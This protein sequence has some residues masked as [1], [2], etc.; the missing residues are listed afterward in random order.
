M[1]DRDLPPERLIPVS[2]E[3][4]RLGLDDV[5][6]VEDL[7]WASGVASAA[8]VLAS[9]DRVRVGIG[10]MP[11][12]LRNAALLA[13][14]V[15]TLGRLHPGRFVAG[16]GH[17]VQDWMRQVGAAAPSPLTLLDETF[18]AVREL[19]SGRRLHLAGKAVSIDGVQLVHPP[20]APVPL[21]AGVTGPKS[22]ELAGRVADGVILVEGS[23]AEQIRD[24]LARAGHP[25]RDYEVVVFCHLFIADDPALV[26]RE[27]GTVA[28]E[29]FR[30]EERDFAIAAGTAAAAAD[31]V[32]S[33]W[34]SGASTVVLRPIGDPEPQ[35]AALVAAM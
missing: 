9:T 13:M 12:P 24:A 29:F 16:L 31:V 11:A 8:T 1:I 35:L 19:V 5:W 10:L 15:A 27:V 20:A 7:G 6:L 18:G 14:E 25:T 21:L 17:G 28:R 3:A 26:E 23:G 4:E 33:L 34:A 30:R 32:R 22:L 2:R